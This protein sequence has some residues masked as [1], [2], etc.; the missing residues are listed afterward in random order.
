MG[1]VR[2]DKERSASQRE[3]TWVPLPGGAKEQSDVLSAG[4]N[5]LR[6]GSLDP[7]RP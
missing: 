6:P 5:G 3:F 2:P 1:G 7:D 4:D